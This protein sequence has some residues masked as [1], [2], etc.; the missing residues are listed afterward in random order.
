MEPGADRILAGTEDGLWEVAGGGA[1]AVATLAG[2]PVVALA[3]DGERTWAIVDGTDLWMMEDGRGWTP[4]ASIDGPPATCLAPTAAGILVGTEQAHLLRLAG[5]WVE[6]VEA[7][8]TAP[9]RETWYTPWGDPADVRS[10]SAEP[11]GAVYVNVHV[12]GVVRSTDGGRSWTP[13]LDIETDVH[14]VLAHPARPG[15]VLAAA[16]IGL[17][18]SR[19]G[20]ASWDFATDG[21][22][23]RYLRAVAVAEGTVL[24]SASTG[25][26]GRKAA[27]Y[28]RPLD[29]DTPFA[30]CRDG[31]P[32]WFPGNVDTAC[33]A[34][35]GATVVAGTRHGEVFRSPDGGITWTLA[36][37]GLPEIRC[38][39]PDPTA[40]AAPPR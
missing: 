38:L 24:V 35:A 5:G 22:H 2:S 31:L 8:E 12:G 19:D 15:L 6:P 39:L 37:K 32:E 11:S 27:V 28:R 3:R 7:F 16:A 4:V 36:A 33:L 20:G 23:A 14:Q 18:L 21:L 10:I 29:G 9:G 34:A 13:T 40:G 30:R 26:G 1:A 25:P 17:G